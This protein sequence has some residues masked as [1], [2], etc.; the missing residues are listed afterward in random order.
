MKT[1]ISSLVTS[2][3]ALAIAGTVSAANINVSADITTDTTWTAD[4]VY[5]LTQQVYVTNG[6]TLTIEPGTIVASTP[7]M[8]GAGALAI[9]RG[10]SINAAG[11]AAN[12]IIFTSTNDVDTWDVQSGTSTGRNPRTG[13]WRV[14]ANEW[15]NIT[16]MGNAYISNFGKNPPISGNSA[17]PGNNIAPMEGL[18]EAFA[19]DTRVLYGGT[20]DNDDSGTLSYVSLRY[21]GRVVGLGNELNGLSLGGIGRGTDINHVEIMNNVDDG[22]E[23]WGGT[24]N[25]KN[26][27][28]W[29]IGDDSLD[30]DQGWRG[31]AQFGLIVQGYSLD[32][33]SQGGGVGDNLLEIDGAEAADAQPVT[34]ATLYNLT[35]IGEPNSGD[36]ATDWRDGA[37]VQI[38]QSIFA[39]VGDRLVSGADNASD[40]E[41]TV[42]GYGHNGTLPFFDTA[43]P[44]NP[45][46]WN[47][48]YNDANA[49]NV[50]AGTG[51]G[52][53]A[54]LYTAQSAGD[55][56]IGQGF[57]T[58]I[59]DCVFFD[60][61]S[62][63]RADQVGVTIAGGSNP[64]K[65]NVVETSS[66][67]TALTRA[68]AVTVGGTFLQ[69]RVIFLDPRPVGAAATSAANP[70]AFPTDPFYTPVS[71]RGAF[72]P[73]QSENWLNGWAASNAFG[74]VASTPGSSVSDW[75]LMN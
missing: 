37:R 16:I 44:T 41:G 70:A 21:G 11:T 35:V 43:T 19:G 7:T 15:G 8:V 13:T 4:N 49:Y 23:I 59:T 48:A 54:S 6:A 66:P 20:D 12:P 71:Y 51:T 9:V 67:F 53:P 1:R 32:I 75:A 52:S 27:S 38:R 64:A 65:G 39:E 55:S 2:A 26:F 34:S 74:F 36:H 33:N 47:T 28:I 14:A 58:E 69:Q 31:K 68:A 46:V 3:I 63:S 72:S 50:N 56:A 40:G 17:V 24:V 10:S 18:T 73:V 62:Y 30:V 61:G 22:I 45:H 25:I 29:N 5:N 60:I 42:T 57:L